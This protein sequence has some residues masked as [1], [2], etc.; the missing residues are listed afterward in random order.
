MDEVL[1]ESVLDQLKECSVAQLGEVCVTLDLQ[2]PPTKAG[3]E[4]PI[5]NIIRNHLTSEDIEESEDNG[6]ALLKA[7][8]KRLNELV[9]VTKKT[10]PVKEELAGSVNGGEERSW[11]VDGVIHSGGISGKERRYGGEWFTDVI[12]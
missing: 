7:V 2:I 9:G 4:G 10:E 3:K 1:L 11:N 6:L 12:S 5:K 8:E